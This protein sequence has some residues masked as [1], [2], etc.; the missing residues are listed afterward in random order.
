MQPYTLLDIPDTI[1]GRAPRM[2]VSRLGATRK[3]ISPC[4]PNGTTDHLGV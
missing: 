1:E 2:A 4:D 3:F